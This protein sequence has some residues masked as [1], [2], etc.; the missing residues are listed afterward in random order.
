M[1]V[2]DDEDLSPVHGSHQLFAQWA[3]SGRGQSPINRGGGWAKSR[4]RPSLDDLMPDHS[5]REAETSA[6]PDAPA[7]RVGPIYEPRTLKELEDIF[8][9][10][11]LMDLLDRLRTEIGRRLQAPASERIVLGQDAHILLSASGSLGFFD[12]SQRCS[13]MERACLDGTDLAAPLAAVRRSAE[14]AV[15]AIRAIRNQS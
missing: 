7:P 15:T 13:E 12:L 1:I 5:T 10:A 11:R 4:P 8:G 14:A 3:L 6:A 9:R 2:P